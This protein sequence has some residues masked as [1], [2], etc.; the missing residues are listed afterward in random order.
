MPVHDSY[1]SSGAAA[2]TT[3]SDAEADASPS[4]AGTGTRLAPNQPAAPT[5]GRK[6]RKRRVTRCCDQCQRKP[7]LCSGFKPCFNCTKKGITCSYDRPYRRGLATTPPP[8]PV[9]DDG[10]ARNWAKPFNE[11]GHEHR[12]KGWIDRACDRCR[13]HKIPCEGKLP[14]LY[15]FQDRVECTF[16]RRAQ[17]RVSG[18]EHDPS[19]DLTPQQLIDNAKESLTR[20][21]WGANGG[22]SWG[23]GSALERPAPTVGPLQLQTRYAGEEIPPLVFLHKAWHKISAAQALGRNNQ[24]SSAP[25]SPSPGRLVLHAG[26]QPFHTSAPNV[27]PAD[28]EMWRLM[29]DKFAT[30]WTETFH[31]LHRPTAW[32]WLLAVYRNW[33]DGKPLETGIGHAKAT[34]PIMT[35]ALST[36]FNYRPWRQSRKDASWNWLWTIGTGDDLFAATIRLTDQEP[37]PPTIHSVQARLLQVFYL[38]CTCRLS[39]AWYIFGNAV[40]MLTALGLHRRRGKNRGLGHEIVTQPNYA[41]IQCERRTFWSAYVIDKQLAMLSG[42]P[43]YL[44]FDTVDQ[45]LPDCVNDED[46]GPPGP[47]RPHKGDCYLEALVEQAKLW[48]L[49]EKIQRQVYTLDDTPEHERLTCAL[50]LGKALEDWKAQLPYLMDRI[51]PSLLGLTYRRQQQLLHLSYWHAQI[52]VYRLFLTAPYPADREAKQTADFAI[53]TCLEAVRTT[54]AMTVNLAREQAKRDKSHFHTLVYAH[55]LMYISASITN[56]I[57]RIRERQRLF[58]GGCANHRDES[59]VQLSELAQKVIKAFR[60]S[61]SVYSPARTWAVI[62]DEMREEATRQGPTPDREQDAEGYKDGPQDDLDSADERILEDALRAHWEA[63]IARE[64]LM[65]RSRNSDTPAEAAPTIVARL[66]DKWKTTDWLD[67]DSA[68]SFR[69]YSSET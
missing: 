50:R 48:K 36:M 34:I 51:K 69:L 24:T 43:A 9:G 30:G 39:Q 25:P 18:L 21:Q 52:L 17:Q 63:D 33:S 32:D 40:N 42:R 2:V 23:D 37:G 20:S 10:T 60:E 61:T 55:H 46:M 28:I 27:F 56:L 65:G 53:R 4:N 29:Q 3:P 54:L 68:V 22:D 7:K 49:I 13:H 41:S 14:C 59:D 16:K 31:F 26:D 58:G 8:P 45:E 35:M 15:C 38:L 44:S 11:K 64:A 66:W 47:F 57:P 6:D 19:E 1:D 67:L 62:L 5:S 12:D